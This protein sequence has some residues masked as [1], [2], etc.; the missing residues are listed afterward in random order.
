MIHRKLLV[1]KRRVATG[2][3]LGLAIT[4]LAVTAGIAGNMHF[5]GGGVSRSSVIF[6]GV[7]VGI[8][9]DVAEVLVTADGFVTAT[10]TNRGGK[11]APG[12]N[13]IEVAVS[14]SDI[15]EVEDNGRAD[16]NL[17]VD[18][19]TLSDIFPSPTPKTAGC[20]NGKWTVSGI[21]EVF[22]TDVTVEAIDV[23][24]GVTEDTLF[25]DCTGVASGAC[26]EVTG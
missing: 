12:R 25:F 10:C 1:G 4:L 7:L 2:L 6:E 3:I 26:P 22:I 24:N 14:A 13:L 23:I 15:F 16:I 8:G 17:I 19:P 21:E 20:P 9:S 11:D 18:D 5:S